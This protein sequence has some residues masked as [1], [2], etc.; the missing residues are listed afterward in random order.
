MNEQYTHKQRT[1]HSTATLSQNLHTFFVCTWWWWKGKK[2]GAKNAK[3]DF[4]IGVCVC[5]RFLFILIKSLDFP[6]CFA[7]FYLLQLSAI[8]VWFDSIRWRKRS[9]PNEQ[10][11]K[12]DWSVADILDLCI[13]ANSFLWILLTQ[14]LFFFSLFIPIFPTIYYLLVY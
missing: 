10:G 9:K 5:V 12:K 14:I 7:I 8:F 6:M 11:M 1:A 4:P 2:C 13:A 3:L